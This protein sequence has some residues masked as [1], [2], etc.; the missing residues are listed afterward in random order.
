MVGVS[1]G[2]I[3]VALLA[4]KKL[5]VADV[6][7]IYNEVGKQVFKQT[8]LGGITGIVKSHSYYDTAGYQRILQVKTLNQLFSH[9]CQSNFRN[10][11]LT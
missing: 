8:Y 10:I 6:E 1:T 9:N 5:A 2:S 7:S 4:F 11:L 3:I